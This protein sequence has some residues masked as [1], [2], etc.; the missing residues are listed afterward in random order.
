MLGDLENPSEIR[1]ERRCSPLVQGSGT[2]EHDL[3]VV[4]SSVCGLTIGRAATQGCRSS[5]PQTNVKRLAF[6]ISFPQSR[7][8]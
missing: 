8:K 6:T 4:V 1:K 2:A 3:R 5:K 7:S